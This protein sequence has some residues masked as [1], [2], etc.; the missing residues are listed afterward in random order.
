MPVSDAQRARGQEWRAELADVARY[1]SE[2]EIR[3]G[4]ATPTLLSADIV[5]SLR[6][7]L[8]MNQEKFAGVLGVHSRSVLGWEAGVKAPGFPSMVK[9]LMAEL[10]LLSTSDPLN[11]REYNPREGLIGRILLSG[12]LFPAH[13]ITNALDRLGEVM[14]TPPTRTSVNFLEPLDVSPR[15]ADLSDDDS[16]DE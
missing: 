10:V 12:A 6:R 14:V 11:P 16:T 9:M 2:G 15:P 7:R 1:L 4:L 3:L 5:S 13:N 8:D